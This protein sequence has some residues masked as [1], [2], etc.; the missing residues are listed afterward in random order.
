M[1]P[2]EDR[3]KTRSDNELLLIGPGEY[4]GAK[5]TNLHGSAVA[6]RG[7]QT[8]CD[9][10]CVGPGEVAMMTVVPITVRDSRLRAGCTGSRSGA[11]IGSGAETCGPVR[12]AG[13]VETE[14]EDLVDSKVK[15]HAVETEETTKAGLTMCQ[16]AKQTGFTIVEL[17][18]VL[19]IIGVAAAIAVPMISSAGSMQIRAA[20]NMLAAD[21]EYAKS[22]AIS[23]GQYY[24]VVFDD[25]AET[26]QIEDQSGTVI[27]HPVKKGFNYAVDFANDGR[28]SQVNIVDA[29]FDGVS[30][31]TFD[32]LG[33][34]HSGTPASGLSDLNSGEVTLQAG[35][36][37]K[38][39]TVEPVTGFI[40]VSD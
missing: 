25:S 17:M 19:V 3:G 11:P 38:K 34:P 15:R 2:R 14:P 4:R 27:A 1:I 28:L 7:P 35:N 8:G 5:R 10:A 32:Y 36:T 23:R 24:S 37:T 13:T 33:S 29:D 40:S 16:N 22:A 9:R 26:Y 30:A 18:I 20:A 12:R 39:V 31:V 6:F 21:L